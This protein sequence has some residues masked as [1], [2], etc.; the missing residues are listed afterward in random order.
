M[1]VV[2]YFV[3]VGFLLLAL[4]FAA[5]RLLQRSVGG[6]LNCPPGTN[7]DRF[8]YFDRMEIV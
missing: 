6:A 8:D 5:D 3:P 1:T 4:L 7:L 2:R